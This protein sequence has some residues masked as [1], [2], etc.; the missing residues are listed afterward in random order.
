MAKAVVPYLNV[1]DEFDFTTSIDVH[2]YL[3]PRMVYYLY[4]GML[5]V[6]E[7]TLSLLIFCEFFARPCERHKMI[8]PRPVIRIYLLVDKRLSSLYTDHWM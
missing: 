6:T 5:N 1:I 2:V 4:R 3:I 8:G 7:T